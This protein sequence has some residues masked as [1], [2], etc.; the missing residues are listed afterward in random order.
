[1]TKTPF[2]R[3]E[4]LPD[5]SA[6]PFRARRVTET[7]FPCHPSRTMR[8]MSTLPPEPEVPDPD[9]DEPEPDEDQA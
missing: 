6:D 5:P 4:S 3:D 9:P 7:P 2:R 1:M 8:A